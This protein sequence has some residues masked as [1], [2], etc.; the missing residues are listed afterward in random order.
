[1]IWK[2]HISFNHTPRFKLGHLT[3]CSCKWG[4]EAS[5][6]EE[7]PHIQ[8]REKQHLPK[9]HR[10]L[11]ISERGQEEEDQVTRWNPKTHINVHSYHFNH[12]FL[13]FTGCIILVTGRGNN[14]PNWWED[15]ECRN[16]QERK[17][18]FY[19]IYFLKN[20]IVIQ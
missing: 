7:W 1:M 20:K 8:E 5:S 13:L 4:W 11:R 15:F 14:Y 9:Y 3:T 16:R 6:P 12:D 18:R 19:F 10:M 2:L 17:R